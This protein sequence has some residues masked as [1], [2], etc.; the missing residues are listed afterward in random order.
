M[1][2]KLK[3]LSFIS[4][5]LC[6][7]IGS[8]AQW[9]GGILLS[10]L[11]GSPNAGSQYGAG[12]M[13][14]RTLAGHFHLGASARTWFSNNWHEGA[15][16]GSQVITD[17]ASSISVIADYE[18]GNKGFRPYLGLDAGYYF[19]KV[20]FV[21]T[22]IPPLELSYPDNYFGAAPKLGLRYYG[23]VVTPFLQV[24]YHYMMGGDKTMEHYRITSTAVIEKV[25]MKSYGTFI[26]ADLGILFK[27]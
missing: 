2:T 26:T 6:L 24:Q 7:S 10:Y 11:N 12:V 8:K 1:L 16:T 22:Y 5:C 18:F 3:M 15:L 23:G 19:T 9:R 20:K 17:A 4:L 13:V 25:T 21:S 14:D 27:F